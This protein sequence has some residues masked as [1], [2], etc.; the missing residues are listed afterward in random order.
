MLANELAEAIAD[1]A[2]AV[3]RC[4]SCG[5]FFDSGGT[6][7][8]DGGP[9]FFNRADA[10]AVGLA[11]GAVDG[12]R[13]GYTHF[14]AM[15]EERDVGRIGI[16]IANK[17]LAIAGLADCRFKHPSCYSWVGQFSNTCTFIPEHFFLLEILRR[18]KWLMYQRPSMYRRSPGRD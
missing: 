13:F 5:S 16:A 14:G 4:R 11:Q 6:S 12:P 10:N 9:D 17:T 15:D 3:S 7:D 2:T 18:P 1:G 8:S